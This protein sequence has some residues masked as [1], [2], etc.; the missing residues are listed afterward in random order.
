MS[1]PWFRATKT[2]IFHLFCT[3]F[4]GTAHS[5][6]VGSV[7]VMS[8]PDFAAWL[9]GQRPSR[10][11]CRARPRAVHEPRLRGMPRRRAALSMRPISRGLYGRKVPLADGRFA[12]VDDAYLRDRILDPKTNPPAG[13]DPIM[14]SFKGEVDDGADPR[15]DRLYPL[16]VLEPG[17][18][19]MTDASPRSIAP[20]PERARAAGSYLDS[21]GGGLSEWLLTTDHKRIALLYALM[22]TAFFFIGGAAATLIRLELFSP[23][24]HFLTDDGYNRAFTLHG[25][26][27]VWFFLVP[28]IPATFGNFLLPLMIGAPDVAFPKLNLV[29]WYLTLIGGLF[30]LCGAARGRRRYRAGPSIRPTR[31]PSPT[32]MSRSRCS[33][34]SSRG[35]APLR[36]AS[37]SLRPSTCCARQA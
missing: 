7:V 31:P 14:P 26:I 12:L 11:P 34:C 22:I 21:E 9:A 5:G 15:A 3:Q 37:I 17:S 33:A 24:G 28:L 8:K 36:P 10:R 30:V 19:P 2:G 29:S 25:I 16:A 6:M 23:H 35:S 18:A 13:Y 20:L 27:M 1:R 32:A 4:C